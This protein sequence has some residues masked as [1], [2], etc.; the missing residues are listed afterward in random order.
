MVAPWVECTGSDHLER[1]YQDMMDKG[2]EGVILR[3]PNSR[4]IPGRSEGYLKH[5]VSNPIKLVLP[6][7][8]TIQ[9]YRDAEAKIVDNSGKHAWECELYAPTSSCL[10]QHPPSDLHT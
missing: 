2:A 10:Q 3:D 9:K 8:N 1:F 4:G 7:D 6:A 5:K